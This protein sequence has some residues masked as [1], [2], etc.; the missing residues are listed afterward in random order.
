MGTRNIRM[1]IVALLSV[2]LALIAMSAA[3]SASAKTATP[4]I[5]TGR[6]RTGT[7]LVIVVDGKSQEIVIDARIEIIDASG[8]VVAKAVIDKSGVA[9]LTVKQGMYTMNV[10]AEGYQSF[11][12][13]IAVKGGET[14]K[15]QVELW[16]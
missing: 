4:G 10:E 12:T 3:S 5:D 1:R 11:I 13:K 9:A 16:Q 15:N 8:N 2:M 14:S 6:I 7:A